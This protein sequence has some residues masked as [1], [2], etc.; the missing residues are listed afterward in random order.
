MNEQ[1]YVMGFIM[2]TVYCFIGIIGGLLITAIL[3]KNIKTN[4]KKLN[5]FLC[6]IPFII[7]FIGSIFTWLYLANS[8]ILAFEDYK[9]EV[10]L[11]VEN[12]PIQ[13]ISDDI[14]EFFDLA[15]RYEYSEGE[16]KVFFEK[17]IDGD[18]ILVEFKSLNN[19]DIVEITNI[20]M[21]ER[22]RKVFWNYV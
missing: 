18:S 7:A 4:K 12:A 3:P 22:Y 19:K 16:Y 8:P 11:N 15:K 5:I 6:F 13:S 21:L 17:S 10:T 1:L 9:T 20:K 14:D 2:T